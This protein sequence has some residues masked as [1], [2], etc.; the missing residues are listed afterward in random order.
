M[1]RCHHCQK[2][3]II[4]YRV[5]FDQKS[6]KYVAYCKHHSRIYKGKDWM[7][8]ITKDEF[9]ASVILES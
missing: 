8:S 4:F 9:L 6:V 3:A 1:I 2:E 5:P 7:K